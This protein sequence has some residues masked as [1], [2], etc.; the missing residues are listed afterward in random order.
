MTGAIMLI[1]DLLYRQHGDDR[2]HGGPGDC[3]CAAVVPDAAAEGSP[4]A[5][6]EVSAGSGPARAR[7]RVEAPFQPH[8]KRAVL[9]QQDV[10]GQAQL[11]LGEVAAGRAV[12]EE[13]G[14]ALDPERAAPSTS[15][16]STLV[17][18]PATLPAYSGA[19]SPRNSLTSRPSRVVAL[20]QA[21]RGAVGQRQLAAGDR[22]AR[23]RRPGAQGGRHERREAQ[24]AGGLGGRPP[25]GRARAGAQAGGSGSVA[26][27]STV[28]PWRPKNS[29]TA[30]RAEGTAATTAPA[31]TSRAISAR[32]SARR[33]P[34]AGAGGG[35][36]R[37]ALVSRQA[38]DDRLRQVGRGRIVELAPELAACARA[39][40]W[41][42]P[43]SARSRSS[44]RESR[45]LTVPRAQPSAAAVSSSERSRK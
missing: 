1:T 10:R 44:A 42:T 18:S 8:Q 12:E 11:V 35:R 36:R 9:Q 17:A 40:S 14:R 7:F 3:L 27:R 31:R 6:S 26:R 25:A 5:A 41:L 33:R 38:R 34:A 22:G 19:R 28:A 21:G 15:S 20:R 32:A 4:A 30:S 29:S 23:R 37:G 24:L 45:D 16:G 13:V 43:I 2:R 39:Q